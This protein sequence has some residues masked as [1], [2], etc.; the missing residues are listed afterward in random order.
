MIRKTLTIL[1]LS[2]LL[3][4]VGLWGV[5]YFHLWYGKPRR[6]ATISF[7]AGALCWQRGNTVGFGNNP[8]RDP[9]PEGSGLEEEQWN[10]SGFTDFKTLFKPVFD[11]PPIL[12]LLPFWI[13][14]L[15]FVLLLCVSF[16]PTHY[17]RCRKR[18]KSG[19]CISCGYDLQGLIELRCPECKT[20]FERSR[21]SPC[22]RSIE[23]QD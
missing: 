7:R 19:L 21:I 14:T 17:F 4:S 3:L 1:S 5:S 11:S 22:S 13:P 16:R 15:F 10:L 12:L 8:N 6:S 9:R 18:E 23:D 2:G 20:P